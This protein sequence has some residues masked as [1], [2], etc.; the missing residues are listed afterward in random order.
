[1]QKY[2]E[3]SN[4]TIISVSA[5]LSTKYQISNCN[6]DIIRMLSFLKQ[7]IIGQN[8][9]IIM[10]KMFSFVHDDLMNRLLDTS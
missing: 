6:H 2:G 9:N 7:D 3:N 4:I 10:P 5:N 8:I 1:M